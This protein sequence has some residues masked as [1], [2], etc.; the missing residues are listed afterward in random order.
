[1]ARPRTFEEADIVERAMLRFWRG[2]FGATSITDLEDAT[3]ISRISLYNAFG[4]KD[5]LFLKALAKYRDSSYAFFHSPSFAQGGL[6]SIIDLFESLTSDRPADAPEQSGCLMLNTILDIDSVS[7]AARAL[8]IDCRKDMIAGFEAALLTA[9][10]SGEMKST[11]SERRER[12]EFLVGAMWGARIIARLVGSVA[13]GRGVAQ[14]VVRTV[15]SWKSEAS[16]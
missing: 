4:D 14:T 12:A 3:G 7:E 9:E 2:G 1:M 15:G 5:G 16:T 11:R 6:G 13:A 8:V 10:A